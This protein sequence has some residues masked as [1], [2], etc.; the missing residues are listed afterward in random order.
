[1]KLV[2]NSTQQLAAVTV[3]VVFVGQ[4]RFITATVNVLPLQIT[5]TAT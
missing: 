3:A 1:L 4:N 5:I 2:Y